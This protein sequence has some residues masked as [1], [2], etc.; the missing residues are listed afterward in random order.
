[1]P[2]WIWKTST[3][4]PTFSPFC[5]HFLSVLVQCPKKNL[6]Q[7]F[8]L[9]SAS[10]LWE[11]LLLTS[12]ACQYKS[13]VSLKMPVWLSLRTGFWK[14]GNG[15]AR[16]FTLATFTQLNTK[17]FDDRLSGHAKDGKVAEALL[18][19][20]NW[21]YVVLQAC[22]VFLIS[23]CWNWKGFCQICRI[24]LPCQAEPAKEPS[25]RVKPRWWNILHLLFPAAM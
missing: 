21:D 3:F 18:Q 25:I 2:T 20:N 11:I 10:F 8:P 6:L 1:M 22:L 24:T 5:P 16:D 19:R 14:A 13:R 23:D 9:L 7:L 17:A 4:W 12:T 15:K